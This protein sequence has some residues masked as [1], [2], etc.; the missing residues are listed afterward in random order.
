MLTKQNWGLIGLLI[1]LPIVTT[2]LSIVVVTHLLT[3]PL[4]LTNWR[5]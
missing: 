2:S 3:T 1:H 4:F 5:T